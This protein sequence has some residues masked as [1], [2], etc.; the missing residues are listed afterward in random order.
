MRG[1]AKPLDAF[2][3]PSALHSPVSSQR[4][5]NRQGVGWRG[6]GHWLAAPQGRDAEFLKG[7]AVEVRKVIRF[8]VLVFDNPR[9]LAHNGE[10]RR[11]LKALLVNMSS[12]RLALSGTRCRRAPRNGHLPI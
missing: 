11:H 5:R 2:G 4:P 1:T 8:G 7:A 6:I 12:T 9:L 3:Q 10:T